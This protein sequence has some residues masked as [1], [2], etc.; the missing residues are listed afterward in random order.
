MGYSMGGGV[1]LRPL[2][3]QHAFG[4][5]HG[6]LRAL[7]PPRKPSFVQS[8]TLHPLVAREWDIG[9]PV[10]AVVSGYGLS[11]LMTEAL[12]G[13]FL[14]GALKAAPD[15]DAA[16]LVEF[17]MNDG[18]LDWLALAPEGKVPVRT[19]TAESL[20]QWMSAEQAKWAKVV[21]ESG[22]AVQ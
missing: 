6:V 9:G 12:G 3:R 17:M 22:I 4:V 1:A 10:A 19:G 11:D 8:L 21:K 16:K 7:P 15:A 5:R 14:F 2:L 13:Y 18:Y 20:G